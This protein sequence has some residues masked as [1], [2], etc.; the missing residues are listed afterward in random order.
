MAEL[1]EIRDL[2]IRY[3]TVDGVV[4]AVNGISLKLDK[5]ST[6][7]LVG[8]TGRQLWQKVS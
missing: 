2:F 5:G 1:L 7:G 6:L 4:E 8:E 3:E